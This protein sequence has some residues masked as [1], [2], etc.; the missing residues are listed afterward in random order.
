MIHFSVKVKTTIQRGRLFSNF[1]QSTTQ[2][3][4]EEIFL[5]FSH[6]SETIFDSLNSESLAKSKEVCRSWYQYLDKQKF[7]HSR[8]EKVKEVV[9]TVEMFEQISRLQ[10]SKK[11][12]NPFDMKTK[13]TIIDDAR[14]CH[15]D[16]VHA[17]IMKNIDAMNTTEKAFFR[18]LYNV[19]NQK[20]SR[21]HNSK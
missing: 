7:L 12:K 2:Q 16:L 4:M 19:K 15:F 6:L 5:R 11:W 13:K 20:L 14:N 1:A 3:I 18:E 9:K 10:I 8:A 21:N 17:K